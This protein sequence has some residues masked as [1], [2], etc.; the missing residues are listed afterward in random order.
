MKV[1]INS[2]NEVCQKFINEGKTWKIS[3]IE[4]QV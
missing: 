1:N 4:I 3:P 2:V